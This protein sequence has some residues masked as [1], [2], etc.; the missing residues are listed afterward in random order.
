MRPPLM[1]FWQSVLPALALLVLALPSGNARGAAQNETLTILEPGPPDTLNPLLTRTAAGADATAGVFDSLVRID[2]TGTFTPDLAMSWSRSV[3]ARIWTFVLNPR[4]RWQDGEPVTANDVAFTIRLVRDSRFGAVATRGFDL[5]TSV[6]VSGTDTLTVTLS[7]AFAPFLATVGT[8]P[9]LP[10][11]LLGAI[12]PDQIRSYAPFN[13]RPVG[14]G[15]FA[16]LSFSSDGRVVEDANHDY[17]GAAPHLSRL[18]IAPAASRQAALAAARSDTATLLPPSFALTP[19]DADPFTGTLPAR[20][21][22][23]P[24][25]AWTHLDLIEH[26]ALAS[27]VV[28]R[29]LALATPRDTIIDQALRGHGRIADGDQA[30]GTPAYEPA[31]HNSYHYDIRAA[32]RLLQQAGFVPANDGTMMTRPITGTPSLPFVV[33]LWGDAA[34]L[35]CATTLRLVAAGWKAAGVKTVIHLIPTAQLFGPRGPLYNPYRFQSTEYDAVLFAWVNGP[36]PDDTIYWS[37][38]AIVTATNPLGGNFSGYANAAF[39]ALATRALITPNGP[40]R[41]A[42]YRRI[43][44][45]LTADAAAVFLYWADRVSIAPVR[46]QGY[47][48]TPYDAAVTWNVAQWSLRS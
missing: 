48:P 36:D 13:R 15:P 2:A 6:T 45:I 34:C 8:T 1:R 46:L 32:R 42:L 35:T 12:P 29:A 24:S 30:P 23:T 11:H 27:I 33:H 37:R 38:S 25:F 40:G 43:Q 26:G 28:R 44:H 47:D 19:A 5:I 3:D 4:A 14:S 16:V 21:L 41:Y 31:L 10:E 7:A 22:Y 18:V 20:V 9:I 17:F 39:D